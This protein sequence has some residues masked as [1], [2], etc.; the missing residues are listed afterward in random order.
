[1]ILIIRMSMV[2]FSLHIRSVAYNRVRGAMNEHEKFL[3]RVVSGASDA[4][5][6]FHGMCSMLRS[7]GFQE[8]IIRGNHHIFTKENVEEIL[9]L[10]PK[11]EV[12]VKPYQVRLVRQVILKYSLGGPQES[13]Q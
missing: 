10:Q 1:M 12:K 6:W 4:S 2:L 5:I 11:A 13:G 3:S 9:N 8:H 7:L